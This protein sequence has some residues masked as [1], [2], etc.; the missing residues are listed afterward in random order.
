MNITP[1]GQACGA[2]I[3]GLDLSKPLPTN[4]LQGIRDAWLEHHV[5][6][7]PD[8][9]LDDEDLVRVTQALGDVGDDPF[10]VPINK[11]TPV[12]AL[13][14]RADEQA[15][16]FAENWHTDWSFKK[17]P[18]IGT[19]LYSL[20]VP[21]VGGNTGFAN[22][23]MALAQMPDELRNRLEGKVALH[24]A[25][26]AYGP[27]GTYGEKDQGNDR[28]MKILFSEQANKSEPHPIVVKHPESGNDTLFGTVGYI[29]T[30][31]GLEEDQSQQL[32]M[33]LYHWQTREE[34]QYTH[35]WE[36]NT[37]VV[38]DNRSVLHRAYGG[39]DGYARELHR[40]TI[41]GSAALSL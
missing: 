31:V 11:K 22:Q 15:P 7:F 28:S 9:R 32:I 38:W 5:L 36:P 14:R 10:F 23:Q 29:H 16:V 35:V 4:T 41:A 39:Y 30:I 8:Q 34:F 25:A 19:C 37:L 2:R 12:V 18:P 13:T 17:Y 20:V 1:S 24:S 21:P 6:A 26:A 27:Q 3:T 33:D 40:L